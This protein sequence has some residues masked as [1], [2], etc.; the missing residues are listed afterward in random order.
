MWPHASPPPFMQ[1]TSEST[2]LK[3][4]NYN[5]NIPVFFPAKTKTPENRG[6]NKFDN[7]FL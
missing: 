4:K 3:S 5:K 2:G 7:Y 6:L 1:T